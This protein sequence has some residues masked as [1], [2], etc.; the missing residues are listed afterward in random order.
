MRETGFGTKSVIKPEP[1][2]RKDLPE[3]VWVSR[4]RTV[5]CDTHKNDELVGVYV[6]VFMH[7]FNPEWIKENPK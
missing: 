3:F 6:W 7:A 2:T 4:V 1:H 5:W